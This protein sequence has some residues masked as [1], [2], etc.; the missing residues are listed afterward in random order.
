MFLAILVQPDD[1]VPIKQAVII[2]L[3]PCVA[4]VD[5]I[6]CVKRMNWWKLGR[7]S[8]GDGDNEKGAWL[9]PTV[10]QIL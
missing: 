2:E 9:F 4:A 8:A 10:R 5:L 3:V 1:T 7:G 6:L